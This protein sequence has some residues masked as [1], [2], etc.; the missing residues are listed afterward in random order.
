MPRGS[1]TFF[2]NVTA[3]GLGRIPWSIELRNEPAGEQ[4]SFT[5][6]DEEEASALLS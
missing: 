2:F 5:W 6:V 3:L 1:A 4:T